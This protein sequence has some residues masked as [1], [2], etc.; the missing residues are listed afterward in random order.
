MELIEAQRLCLSLM[1]SHGL[2]QDGWKF[3]YSESRT[4]MGEC[5]YSTK[6]ISVS[7]LTA[8][9]STAEEIRQLMLHEIAH[10]FTFGDNHGKRWEKKARELGYTG[11]SKAHNPYLDAEN[12][13]L[14]RAALTL[15]GTPDGEVGIGDIIRS[16]NSKSTVILINKDATHFFG[17]DSS[18]KI[19]ALPFSA[20][21]A[22]KVPKD[23][24]SFNVLA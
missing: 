4:I 7:S 21:L 22:H 5:K 24:V 3:V 19:Y 16:A 6:T 23:S 11:G 9:H 20:A 12:A 18:S 2:V 1:T 10:A 15:P 17:A 8:A 13:E 14:I